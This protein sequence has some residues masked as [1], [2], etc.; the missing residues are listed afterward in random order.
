[1][2]AKKAFL[3]HIAGL[4]GLAIIFVL[5][6]HLDGQVWAHG[7]LGVD[8]FLVITGYLLFKSRMEHP[9]IE[10]PRALAQFAAKRVERLVPPMCVI[11]ILSLVVGILFLSPSDEKFACK[12]GLKACLGI[13]NVFYRKEFEDY[14]AADAAFIP[15]LHLWYLAV[16]MQMYLIYAVGNQALQRLPK[17]WV[18]AVLT[19]VGVASVAYCYSYSLQGWVS[20]FAGWGQMQAPSYYDTLPRLWEPLAGGAALWLP[21]LQ[22]KRVWATCLAGVGALLIAIPA[23]VCNLPGADSMPLALVVVLGAVLALRYTPEGYLPMLLTNRPLVWLGRISFSLYLVHMPI[24]VYGC[25]WEHGHPGLGAQLCMVV[26]ALLLGWGFWWCIEKRRFSLRWALVLWLCA[27]LVCRVGRRTDGFK[28]FFPVMEEPVY[29]QWRECDDAAL[30]ADC[31]PLFQP[32][33]HAFY[34]MKQT[35]PKKFSMPLLAMGSAGRPTLLLMGDSHA[36]S[37]FP[38]MDAACREAGVSGV[39]LSSAVLPFHHWEVSIGTDYHFNPAKEQAL[40]D[41]LAA[42]P[43]LSHIVIAQRWRQKFWLPRTCSVEQ[44]ETDLRAFI[45]SLNA[46]HKKVVIIGP[47]PE[48]PMH[49]FLR[50]YRVRHLQGERNDR[51]PICTREAHEKENAH[52]YGILRKLDADGLC[53]LIDPLD[54]LEPGEVFQSVRDNMVQMKDNDHMFSGNSIWLMHRLLPRLKEA[55]QAPPP[56]Q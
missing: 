31:S 50:Y 38:G 35:P 34:A 26:V 14:F 5:L 45:A 15:L 11:I 39:F 8:V 2:G 29:T 54:A 36:G 20:G 19:A 21:S 4:R 24:F 49:A 51:F 9:G 44:Y 40:L 1:M 33:F 28:A 42:H 3:E 16:A 56:V 37:L 43:E 46:I 25:M 12:A 47:T 13:V 48:F 23:L 22:R 18:A 17:R 41:W 32:C 27:M 55:L 53:T 6:F 30:R 52:V 10:G 7:Y